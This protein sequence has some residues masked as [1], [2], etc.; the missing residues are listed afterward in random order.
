MN[1]SSIT[2]CVNEN[3]GSYHTFRFYRGKIYFPAVNSSMNKCQYYPGFY[4]SQHSDSN[5]VTCSVSF[6]SFSDN[7]AFG[8]SCIYFNRDAAK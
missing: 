3:S 6:S 2:R 7:N 8:Y 4:S 5:S 1:Y